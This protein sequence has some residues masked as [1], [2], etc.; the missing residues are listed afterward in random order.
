MPVD[1]PVPPGYAAAMPPRILLADDSVTVQKVIEL[2]FSDEG[3]EV[4]TVGDGRQAIEQIDAAPPDIVLADVSMPERDG[5]EV[6]EHVK[7][8]PALAHIPVIL[9]TGAFEQLDEARARDVGCDGVLAKPFEPQMVV[10]MVRE[11]LARRTA[12]AGADAETLTVEVTS[13]GPAEGFP[14]EPGMPA[15][16]TPRTLDDFFDRIDEALAAPA[17]QPAFPEEEARLTG[18]STVQAGDGGTT[19]PE[20]ERPSTLADAFSELLADELGEA[21]LPASWGAVAVP[22]PAAAMPE[23]AAAPVFVSAPAPAPGPAAPAITDDAIDDV[24]RRVVARMSDEVDPGRSGPAGHRSRGAA[25]PR[26]DR[27]AEDPGLNPATGVA[28]PRACASRYDERLCPM[29]LRL[30]PPAPATFPTNPRSKAS[31]RNGPSAGS[32]TASTASTGRRREIRSTR[33]TR[34]RPR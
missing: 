26:G 12:L 2:T 13:P 8:S 25:R 17:G 23:P 10:A 32:A 15:G 16:K 29:R 24:A 34:R 18:A 31:S 21:P 4:V 6:A 27:A 1:G 30:D 7:G 22:A 20:P 19:P 3:M 33:S 9:M 28:L 14:F 5:Y 11:L